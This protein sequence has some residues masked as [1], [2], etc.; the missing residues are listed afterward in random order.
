MGHLTPLPD[1]SWGCLTMR[2]RASFV[3]I[4]SIIVGYTADRQYHVSNHGH[5]GTTRTPR[6]PDLLAVRS[7]RILQQI[8]TRPYESHLKS[9]NPLRWPA[10][11]TQ[12]TAHV[13]LRIAIAQA[14]PVGH[15]LGPI[16][17]EPSIPLSNIAFTYASFT[18]ASI[19]LVSDQNQTSQLLKCVHPVTN[20]VSALS[21]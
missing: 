5:S 17:V 14:P 20:T 1:G 3:G 7:Q 21:E 15:F 13:R 18:Y 2:G 9:A 8:F 19:L 16:P 11:R 4:R 6:T 10:V 12:V